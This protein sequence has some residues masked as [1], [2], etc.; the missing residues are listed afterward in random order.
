L[1]TVKEDLFNDFNGSVKSLGAWGGDFILAAS[2]APEEYVR[3][4]FKNKN[5]EMIF[6]Y[7]D[8]VLNV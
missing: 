2:P 3:D 4:Y 7:N 6:R 5:L 1:P 8:M